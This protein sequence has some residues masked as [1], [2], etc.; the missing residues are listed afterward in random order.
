MRA[1]AVIV[2]DN[3]GDEVRVEVPAPEAPPLSIREANFVDL[4]KH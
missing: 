3:I 1:D 2:I 4:E